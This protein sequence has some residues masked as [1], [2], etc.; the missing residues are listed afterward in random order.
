MYGNGVP[1]TS[2]SLAGDGVN[3]QNIL[4]FETINMITEMNHKDSWSFSEG[5]KRVFEDL[6]FINVFFK[7]HNKETGQELQ[8]T[9]DLPE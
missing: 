9:T 4:V 2:V 5:Y 7:L 3:L 6:S 1:V 8:T